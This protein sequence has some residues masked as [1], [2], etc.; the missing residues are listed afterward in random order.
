MPKR[1]TNEAKLSVDKIEVE[2]K[3]GGNEELTM[4][5]KYRCSQALQRQVS[6][7]F[8]AELKDYCLSERYRALGL[9]GVETV[10]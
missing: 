1:K 9:S 7:W 3:T 4:V 6:A 10:L 5:L 2:F 8:E